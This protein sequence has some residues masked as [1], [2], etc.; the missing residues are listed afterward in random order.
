MSLPFFYQVDL[1]TK[2]S[3]IH[4]STVDC[5]FRSVVHYSVLYFLPFGPRAPWIGEDLSGWPGGAW[6]PA[7]WLTV[8]MAVFSWR[9]IIQQLSGR[10][11]TCTSTPSELCSSPIYTV[12]IGNWVFCAELFRFLVSII[13]RNSKLECFLF[14][15]LPNMTVII[16]IYIYHNMIHFYQSHALIKNLNINI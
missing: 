10:L 15:M 2:S 5:I 12:I 13:V 1:G 16:I 9:W 11:L 8:I 6:A 7:K 4:K 14:L 3:L